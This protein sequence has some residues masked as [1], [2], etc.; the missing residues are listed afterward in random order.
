MRNGLVLL[1]SVLPKLVKPKKLDEQSH[2]SPWEREAWNDSR[3]GLEPATPHYEFGRLPPEIP[4][5]LGRSAIV[6]HGA[7]GNHRVDVPTSVAK[8]GTPLLAS[9][10]P[11]AQYP[12][13]E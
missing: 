4:P 7:P 1:P 10:S 9:R 11:E 12:C 13:E 6:R 5:S 2:A 8:L 3:A